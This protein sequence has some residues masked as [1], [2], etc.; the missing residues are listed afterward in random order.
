MCTQFQESEIQRLNDF[1]NVNGADLARELKVDMLTHPL[2][3]SFRTL[4]GQMS[5][6]SFTRSLTLI[7]PGPQIE[8][9]ARDL[10]SF[11]K[12]WL[13][14]PSFFAAWMKQEFGAGRCVLHIHARPR[15]V[16]WASSK[17]APHRPYHLACLEF[18]AEVEANRA[19]YLEAELF[20]NFLRQVRAPLPFAPP[21]PPASLI[22][23]SL[24]QWRS[25]QRRGSAYTGS[26]DT[27]QS[28]VR[29][30]ATP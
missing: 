27:L 11:A 21:S 5:S 28:V 25:P 14:L 10:T 8:P 7:R 6:A 30:A 1:L 29:P 23:V 26:E 2:P 22:T 20:S 19:E 13:F 15:C 4:P 9:K 18:L 3:A 16:G 17:L 24:P 12:P